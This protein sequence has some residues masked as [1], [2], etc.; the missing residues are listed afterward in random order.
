MRIGI[1]MV[2]QNHKAHDDRDMYK[3][4]NPPGH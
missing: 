4:R 1:Q 3:E 2:L